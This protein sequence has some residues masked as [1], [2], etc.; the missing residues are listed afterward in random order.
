MMRTALG[1][2]GLNGGG[3][4]GRRADPGARIAGAA[5]GARTVPDG[6]GI[7]TRLVLRGEVS[8][9]G[10]FHV[11]GKFEGE[12]NVTGK[13]FVAEGAQVDANINAAAIQIGG[14]VRGNLSAS[15]RVEI[16]PSG[17]LTGTLKTGSFSAADG[18]SVKGEIWV[19]RAGLARP[20]EVRSGT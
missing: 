13:V 9:E 18:A 1:Y 16:L 2:F 5:R 3:E 17:V 11:L 12:I 8:G 4:L 14:I 6:A 19:E 15:T 10:D 7:G 20:V